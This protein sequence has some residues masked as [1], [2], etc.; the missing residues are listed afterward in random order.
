MNK[1]NGGMTRLEFTKNAL[2]EKKNE[3][4]L[5]SFQHL[6]TLVEDV[7]TFYKTT[8]SACYLPELERY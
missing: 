4:S 7:R 5:P 3:L 6:W 8:K 1:I 2:S